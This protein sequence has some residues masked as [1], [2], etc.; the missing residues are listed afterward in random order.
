MIEYVDFIERSMLQQRPND[1]FIFGDNM[2][3]KGLGG[4]AREMRGEP[5]AIGIPTKKFP[6]MSEA[7]FFTDA[8][9]DIW[10]AASSETFKF[11]RAAA[12][13]KLIIWPK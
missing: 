1:I 8:D 13:I 6:S 7:S 4:Q 2:I 9:V 10:Q 11:L 12:T 3:R 5:N